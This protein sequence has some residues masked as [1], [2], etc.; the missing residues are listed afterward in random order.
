MSGPRLFNMDLTAVSVAL[1]VL[2]KGEVVFKLGEPKPF[3]RVKRD[4]AGNE[5]GDEVFGVGYPLTVEFP[6]EHAGGRQYFQ[7][8][9]HTEGAQGFTKR[10][11]MAALGYD[12]R[13]S[14]Q[15]KIFDEKFRGAD[16]WGINPETGA[17]GDIWREIKGRSVKCEVAIGQHS[18]TGEA[19]QDFKSFSPAK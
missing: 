7:A 1:V 14:A 2:D 16:V 6:E 12:P 15:E 17:V 13:D 3:Y 5:T 10:F 11:V 8:H 19:T 18:K 9:M 4:E